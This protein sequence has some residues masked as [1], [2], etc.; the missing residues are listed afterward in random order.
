MSISVV[1][2]FHKAGYDLYGKRMINSFLKN[3]PSEIK[4]YV[5]AEDCAVEESAPN[6]IVRDLHQSSPELVA[7]KN[8]WKNVPK[9][10]GDVSADPIRSKR[11]DS[12]K[13]FKWHAIRFAHK[14]YSIFACAKEC[15]TE[16]L[17]WMDADTYCHSIISQKTIGRF[18]PGKQELCYLGRRGKYSECGLYAMKLTSQNT[19]D[20][21]TE[22]QRVYDEAENNGI[23]QMAEW[24]DSF[25][26]D[27]VRKRLPKLKQHNWSAML[28]DLRPRPGMSSGEGH[29]LINCE[30]GAYLDHLKGNRKQT[31]MSKRDDLKVDRTEPYWQQFK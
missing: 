11:K 6:L 30:W 17:M 27:E 23:F 13:G 22:F 20:F 16:W 31:G 2:T 9:A 5:Y 10:N 3:W 24:H 14:V 19:Q 18:L 29:P 26:F 12:G 21:V 4:L 7:F 25:V 1:T 8:R 28:G 15:N